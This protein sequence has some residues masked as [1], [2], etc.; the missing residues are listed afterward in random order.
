MFANGEEFLSQRDKTFFYDV[1]QSVAA[2]VRVFLRARDL[3]GPSLP[4]TKAHSGAMV[5]EGLC[6]GTPSESLP[7][8]KLY[9]IENSESYTA[10]VGNAR[11][12]PRRPRYVITIA[13]V[14]ARVY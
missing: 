14:I 1:A 2:L 6:Q 5:K 4:C 13:S 7:S 8:E 12:L 3:Q 9:E 10:R 11:A